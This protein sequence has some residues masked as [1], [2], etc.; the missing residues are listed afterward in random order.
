MVEF[1]K[2][3][4]TF[5]MNI[6]KGTSI[7]L[8]V[9][10]VFVTGIVIATIGAFGY[11]LYLSSQLTKQTKSIENIDKNYSANQGPKT[12]ADI[13]EAK[14][15][16]SSYK[17]ILGAQP[18]WTQI[19]KEIQV[20]TPKKI[21]YNSLSANLSDRAV[22]LDVSASSYAQAVEAALSFMAS[23]VFEDVKIGALSLS[24]S[25]GVTEVGFSLDLKVKA[26]AFKKQGVTIPTTPT[27]GTGQ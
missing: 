8:S 5:S 4:L 6:G 18:Y 7:F 1:P 27:T 24:E 17:Q 14:S 20:R 22:R 3:K 12:E 25:Q 19:L 16:V 9:A 2:A 13:N 21:K 11:G 23:L 15:I 26:D 10:I